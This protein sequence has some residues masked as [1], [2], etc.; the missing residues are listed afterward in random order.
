MSRTLNSFARRAA[1]FGLI[2]VLVGLVIGMLAVIVI[3]QVAAL[4]EARKRTTTSGGYAQ[5]NGAI[6]FYR[7]Q[8]SIAQ[9][10][11]GLNSNTLFKCDTVWK[12][13]SGSDIATKIPLAPVTI[14]PG[15]SIIPA[16]DPNTDT[17]LV[18]S[19]NTN[20]EPQGNPINSSSEEGYKVQMPGAFAAGDRVIAAPSGCSSTLRLDKVASVTSNTVKTSS[21]AAG[22]TLYNLGPAP[23]IQAYA[24]R[25]GN[26]TVCDYLVNDCGLQDPPSILN[27]SSI[28]VP[29]AT[30]I[31]SMRALYGRDTDAD[32]VVNTYD[33]T[34]PGNSQDVANISAIDLV[35]VARSGQYE[36]DAVTTAT[37]NPPA[38][39]GDSI[40][41]LIGETGNLGPGEDWK[42]Y[43]YK[44]FQS[45]V[46]IRNVVW[47]GA[48][49]P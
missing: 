9:A 13:D 16:G 30:N 35:L 31:V 5:S 21:S 14:N 29:V 15:S 40:A 25:G 26:L 33:Q 37:S 20:G 47:M 11:Y 39:A 27:D 46:P 34:A 22:A 38:W 8:R 23:T 6:M 10:G 43:R 45:V 7:L 18:M 41:P 28:W 1:G 3:L 24:V 19:G 17:L 4:S 48:E 42:H 36:K 49:C 32:C 2:E 12:V 44:V